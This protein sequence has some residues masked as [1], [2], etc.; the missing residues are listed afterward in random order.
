MYTSEGGWNWDMM[1][2]L[3]SLDKMY[4]YSEGKDEDLKDCR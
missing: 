3:P 1:S 2:L 4:S